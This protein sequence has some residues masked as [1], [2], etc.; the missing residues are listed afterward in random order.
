VA[1]K[2][3]ESIHKEYSTTRWWLEEKPEDVTGQLSTR[4]TRIRQ[5]HKYRTSMDK[6]HARLYDGSVGVFAS[7][8]DVDGEYDPAQLPFN[9][10]RN[11]IDTLIAMVSKNRPLPQVVTDG[12]DYKQRK[13]AERMSK[14]IEGSLYKAKFWHLRPTIL[15]DAATFGTGITHQYRVGKR[16]FIERVLPMEILVDRADGARG[17]PRCIYFVRTKDRFVLADENPDLREEI[18]S[19]APC[20]H[21][22]HEFVWLDENEDRLLVIDAYRLPNNSEEVEDGAKPRGGRHVTMIQGVKAPLIDEPWKRA[23]FPFSFVRKSEP[24]AGFWGTGVAQEM[25]GFQREI[26]TVADKVQSAHHVMGGG[27]ILVQMGSDIVDSDLTNGVGHIIKYKGQKP[28]WH[29][30]TPVNEATYQYLQGLGTFALQ[31]SGISQMSAQSTKP[32][33]ISAARALLVL[34]DIETQR[35]MVFARSDEEWVMDI[36]NQII[37][38]L[39]EISKTDKNFTINVPNEREMVPIKWK[40]NELQRQAYVLQVFPTS[41]L[42]KTPSAR[43][44]MVQDLFNAKVIDR[45]MFLKLLNA[46]DLNA[47]QDLEAASRDVADAQ[48]QAMLD[49][50]D[51][52]AKDAFKRPEEYQDLIYSMHRAQA[53]I[54]MGKMRGVEE[55]NIQLLRDYIKECKRL[56]QKAMEPPPAAIPPGQPAPAGEIQPGM[57]PGGAAPLTIPGATSMPTEQ[58]GPQMS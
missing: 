26:N 35:F 39:S 56:M 38:L 15:R 24:V 32:P 41:L 51:V 25:A 42:A 16:V 34:D 54:N 40:D 37:D 11:G 50:E 58:M 44:Q 19:A 12:A 47:E 31:Y 29:S 45:S 46:P 43:L 3:D 7:G 6:F 13:M 9:V 5:R 49:A 1:R 21:N 57:P 22:E 10:V 36:G 17:M 55:G 33:G 20:N 18:L 14:G 27:H 52:N 48:I 2:R 23:Y 53:Q 4:A 28:E 8:I 30:P